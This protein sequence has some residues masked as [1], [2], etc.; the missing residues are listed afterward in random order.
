MP[1]KNKAAVKNLDRILFTTDFSAASENAAP[2]ALMLAKQNKAR[3]YVMHVV[4]VSNDM[5]GFYVPHMSYEILDKELE[6]AAGGMIQKFC[7]KQFGGY[8]NV[9]PIVAVGV[10]YKEIMGAIKG[11]NI[12]MVIMAASG[13]GEVGRLLFG[14]TADRVLRHAT[15]PVLVIPPAIR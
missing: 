1:P 14:S 10:P 2:Y 8:K 15:C 11:K 6:V 7:A 13:M 9:E 4:D 3:L 12:N 5:A